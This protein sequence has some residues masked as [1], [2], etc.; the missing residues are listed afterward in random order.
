MHAEVERVLWVENRLGLHARPIAK[1]T[2]L[3]QGFDAEITLEKDGEVADA[4]ELLAILALDCPQGTR[5]V[6]RPD[7]APGPGGRHGDYLA[8]RPQVW[9]DMTAEN[10]IL[11]GIPASPGIVVGRAQVLTEA[12]QISTRLLY[13]E[14]DVADEQEWFR[15]VVEQIEAELTQLKDEI[16]DDLKE[17]DVAATKKFFGFPEDQSFYVPDDAL[18]NWRKAVDRGAA[19]EAEWKKLFAGYATRILS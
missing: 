14:K 1:I 16:T 11:Q 7:R 9:R 15:K 3:A 2:A 12:A 19:L 17:A 4:R 13:T 5:L 18:A 10:R 8:L 6:L